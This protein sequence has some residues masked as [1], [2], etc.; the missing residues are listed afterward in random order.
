MKKS[1]LL[2]ISICGSCFLNG[3]AGGSSSPPPLQPAVVTHFSVTPATAAPIAGTAF[4]F[5][6]TALDASNNTV[7]T[8]AG[9]VHFS[10]SDAKAV[11]PAN[12]TLTN[13]SGTFSAMLKTSGNQTITATDT[14]MPSI[15]SPPGSTAVSPAAAYQFSVTA[16]ANVIAG[17]AFNLTVTA[18]DQF[19]N[20]A[21]TYSGFVH[22]TSSNM[23]ATL[24]ADSMLTN[25]T[26]S[27]SVILKTATNQTITVTD[28][29]S[30]SITATSSSISVSPGALTHF[31]VTAP[32]GTLSGTSLSFA[33]TALD[34]ANN[35]LPAYSGT[36]HFTS[37]D[38]AAK[39]PADS[40]LT[41]GIATFS[42]TLMTAGT[43]TITARDQASITGISNIISVSGPATH[44]SVRAPVTA[45]TGRTIAFTVTPMDASNNPAPVYS[46]NVRFSSTDGLAVLP[47]GTLLTGTPSFF[48]T[49]N[50]TGNQFITV[51]DLGTSTITGTSNAIVVKSPPPLAITSGQPPD[52]ILNLP[53]GGSQLSLSCHNNILSGFQLE[54]SGGQAGRLGQSYSWVGT[55]LPPG[56]K[57][58]KITFVGPPGPSCF[59]G[60][61]WLIDGNPTAT[62][63]YTFS[64]SVTDVENPPVTVSATYTINIRDPGIP[65]VNATPPPPIGTLNSPYDFTFTA[66]GGILPLTWSELGAP[67][68]GFLPLSSGGV[69]SG[70]PTATGSFPITVQAQGS[71]GRSSAPHNFSIQ[72]LANG[73]KPTGSLATARELHTATALGNELVLVTGG[74]NTTSFPTTAELFNPAKAGFS[75]T[76]GGM[77]AVRVSP[78]ANLLQSGKVLVAGGKDAVGNSAATAEIF[79]PTTATFAS[80][81]GN[82]QTARVYHTATVLLDGTVLLTGGLDA[83]GNPTATAEMFDPATKTFSSVGNMNSVRFLHA[84]TLL[85]GGQVLVTGGLNVGTVFDTAELYDP[86]SKTFTLTGNMTVARAGHTVTALSNGKILVTGGASQF[87]GNSLSSAELFDPA[88]GTFTATANMVTARSLHT[89]TLRNDG[90]VLLAGGDTYFYS[91]FSGRTLSAAELFDPVTG[92]FTSAADMATPR[93]SHTATLL[94]NGEILV[95]GGS[96]GTLGYSATTTVLAT[97]ELYQ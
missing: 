9:T 7:S 24:P 3:C 27:F 43:Q 51:S 69:L 86:V 85:A 91:G 73:F 70:I 63:P 62:G 28:T 60:I 26:A 57:I 29:S 59:Y 71:D 81:T 8:Y 11:L 13:G 45:F 68:P 49:F 93:E 88:T 14:A 78:S 48:V 22:F 82:M 2:V 41:N 25:G 20:T 58:E 6:V 47:A 42:A 97:A 15:T 31:S 46:G 90:T 38:A 33:V 79:D 23:Q 17:A 35:V 36:V 21:T 19:S 94:V 72:V 77:S 96:S 18:L 83:T 65:N 30:A 55:S 10:S 64:V 92:T 52:G 54:A 66:A 87:G 80:T 84:A 76:Q 39:L 40:S 95:V 74:V 12:S 32:V 50:T 1:L 75:T 37:T 4:N 16:P 89:A 5:A 53:Y 67:P 56:L 61:V 34:V 44:F